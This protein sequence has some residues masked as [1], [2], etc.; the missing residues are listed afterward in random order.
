MKVGGYSAIMDYSFLCLFG[1]QCLLYHTFS[2]RGANCLVK[3][4]L[5]IIL[6]FHSKQ[7]VLDIRFLLKL[8]GNYNLY[9]SNLK[10]SYEYFS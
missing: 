4:C 6:L 5:G 3:F 1:I 10:V 2:D 7:R 9:D 8:K